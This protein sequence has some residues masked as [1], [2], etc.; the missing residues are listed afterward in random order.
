[1]VKKGLNCPPGVS[2]NLMDGDHGEDVGAGSFE[3]RRDLW[4]EKSRAQAR[5]SRPCNDP[6]NGVF[7]YK[8]VN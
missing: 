2:I 5:R 1:M 8:R 7:P 4:C 6:D 3:G